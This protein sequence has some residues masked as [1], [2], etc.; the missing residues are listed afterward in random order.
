[1]KP[2]NMA[3]VLEGKY[4]D[5]DKPD[6]DGLTPHDIK[7]GKIWKKR[8]EMKKAGATAEEIAEFDEKY[9]EYLQ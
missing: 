1:M 6:Q 7:R 3:K 8:W 4:S 5:R 9:K 2:N